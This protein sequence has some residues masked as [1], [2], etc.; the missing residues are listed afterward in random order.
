MPG[1]Q[2]SYPR[3]NSGF[4]HPEALPVGMSSHA[5]HGRLPPV[6]QQR[7]TNLDRCVGIAT[8]AA[9]HLALGFVVF[10]M[11]KPHLLPTATSEVRIQLLPVAPEAAPAPQVAPPKPLPVVPP[12][13]ERPVQKREQPRPKPTP[14]PEP[15]LAAPAIV[16][17]ASEMTAGPKEAQP[18]PPA[19]VQATAPAPAAPAPSAAAKTEAVAS[20]PRFD[21]DYLSNP[22]P[23]Y[24]R[25]SRTL[26][27]QGKVFL[28][29]LVSAD[30]RPLQVLIDRSSGYPRLDNSAHDTVLSRWKFVPAR[31]GQQAVEGW[32]IV[33]VSFSL[34]S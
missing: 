3:E 13:V 7:T 10:V 29:V 12:P 14:R 23:T 27:E 31:Q 4:S 32:V 33:P 5:W 25:A 2:I 17:T 18:T 9:L 24:P 34:T 28:R 30:G 15:V 26:R 22:Q 6:A 1:H 19:P 8:I 11:V 21:A 20:Q 16:P